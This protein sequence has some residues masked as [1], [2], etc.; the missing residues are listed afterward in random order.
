MKY[1]KLFKLSV[2]EVAKNKAAAESYV[3]KI[4]D[5]QDDLPVGYKDSI[6]KFLEN[7]ALEHKIV[8]DE[9]LFSPNFLAEKIA[10]FI[11][12]P[13]S[14]G[15]AAAQLELARKEMV[16]DIERLY[17]IDKAEVERQEALSEQ[18]LHEENQS[19]AHDLITNGY[20]R[21]TDMGAIPDVGFALAPF[22]GKHVNVHVTPNAEYLYH[23]NNIDAFA[24]KLD[25]VRRDA[26]HTTQKQTILGVTHTGSVH[27]VSYEISIDPTTKKI[28]ITIFDSMQDNALHQR[29]NANLLEN[30]KQAAS[31]LAGYSVAD[32]SVVYTGE[33][34]SDANCAIYAARTVIRRSQQTSPNAYED[35]LSLKLEMVNR[36][37]RAQGKNLNIQSDDLGII[38][39][40]QDN[41]NYKTYRSFLLSQKSANAEMKQLFTQA[42]STTA[43]GFQEAKTTLVKVESRQLSVKKELG[44]IKKE[45]ILEYDYE[46]EARKI[47][48]EV[49]Q[50]NSYLKELTTV[51]QNEVKEVDRSIQQAVKDNFVKL[52]QLSSMAVLEAKKLAPHAAENKPGDEKDLSEPTK[53]YNVLR[54]HT[55]FGTQLGTKDAASIAAEQKI[56][57]KDNSVRT[58]IELDEQYARILQNQELIEYFK[59]EAATAAPSPRRFKK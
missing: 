7:I 30:M 40:D 57:A 46:V 34:D 3:D 41:E 28:G 1:F 37:V 11:Q 29:A 27:F 14:R 54:A 38:F 16:Q 8:L 2:A 55:L 32:S 42:S 47:M 56:S 9:L 31:Q 43:E 36:G 13:V 49:T 52:E 35:I 10:Q 59:K 53:N 24:G 26:E 50:V 25:D 12:D 4:L 23:A 58:Q 33:Q 19:L 39:H 15:L 21:L 45:V 20:I 22:V 44:K 48:S 6:V 17:L 5:G 51:Q 18:A